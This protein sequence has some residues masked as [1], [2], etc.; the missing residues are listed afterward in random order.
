MGKTK[1]A[2]F[3]DMFRSVVG[4]GLFSA[5]ESAIESFEETEPASS[6]VDECPEDA[7]KLHLG[8]CGCGVPDIDSDDDSV[9]DCQDMCP[10]DSS[11]TK[12]AFE[13]CDGVDNNC[14]GVIDEGVTV[15]MVKHVPVVQTL[16][17]VSR[18]YK[19]VRME[20]GQ[21]VQQ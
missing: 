16:A 17:S 9:L 10:F 15:S 1:Y 11:R 13:I 19:C 4:Y 18:A 2:F 20:L 14:D 8:V 12:P 5:C 7:S 3:K 6:F 21:P